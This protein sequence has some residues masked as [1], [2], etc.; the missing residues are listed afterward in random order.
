MGAAEPARGG[1]ATKRRGRPEKAPRADYGPAER[2]ANGTAVMT[3]RADHEAPQAPAIRAASAVVHQEQWFTLGLITDA[4][5]EAACRIEVAAAAAL[6]ARSGDHGG[7]QPYWARGTMTERRLLALK[8]MNNLDAV[9]GG[10]LAGMVLECICDR[11]PHPVGV[12]RAGLAR[13]AEFWDM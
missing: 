8:D 3:Y 13:M 4:E 10:A 6:G 12:V 11:A 7:G 5:Y 1:L 2:H 9:L